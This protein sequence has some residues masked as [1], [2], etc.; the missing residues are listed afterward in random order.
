MYAGIPARWRYDCYQMA[1]NRG[2]CSWIRAGR[3]D[4]REGE[5]W[6]RI[7]SQ[8]LKLKDNCSARSQGGQGETARKQ[9]HR[10]FRVPVL[11]LILQHPR[12]CDLSIGWSERKLL[13]LTTAVWAL[14]ALSLTTSHQRYPSPNTINGCGE[15]SKHD[16][17]A[18]GDW[19]VQF[20]Q[21]LQTAI[22]GERPNV[23]TVL[24]TLAPVRVA[25]ECRNRSS[26]AMWRES[27]GT[28]GQQRFVP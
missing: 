17:M 3:L 15:E 7:E 20:M 10:G 5:G 28:L 8:T 25:K 21:G 23:C 24:R 12:A 4:V 1:K 18:A 27:G 19:P 11:G 14:A 13:T 16:Q 26:G 22:F 9:T 6:I 2:F